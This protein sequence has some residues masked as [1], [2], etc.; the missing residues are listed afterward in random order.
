[1]REEILTGSC[2]GR[3]TPY[4]LDRSAFQHAAAGFGGDTDPAIGRLYLQ[5]Q[6]PEPAPS[7]AW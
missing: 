3:R 7:Y 2:R 4:V 5:I 6:H 1:M